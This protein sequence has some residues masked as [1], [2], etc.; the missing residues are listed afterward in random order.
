[1]TRHKQ[2]SI[3]VI[4]S[5][6]LVLLMTM[7]AAGPTGAIKPADALPPL[8]IQG[9]PYTSEMLGVHGFGFRARES[10]VISLDGVAIGTPTARQAMGI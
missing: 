2:L 8:T 1:M 6:C 5:L 4:C 7:G 9:E 3:T 10:V